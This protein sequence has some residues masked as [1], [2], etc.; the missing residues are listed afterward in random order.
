MNMANLVCAAS[1]VRIGGAS[2]RVADRTGDRVGRSGGI[3]TEDTGVQLQS[4]DQLNATS[5]PG[6]NLL[7][8]SSLEQSA[9]NQMIK[10]T[11]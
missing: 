7:S 1:W 8:N 3:G 10:V 6:S 5:S 2:D 9:I 11:G 4:L